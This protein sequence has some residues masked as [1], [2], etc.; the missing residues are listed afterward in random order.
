MPE[1]RVVRSIRE[2][3]P[4][5]W[6][7]CFPGRLET[8]AYLAAVEAA[9]LEGFD[10]RYLVIEADGQVLA[11][12]PG[13]LVDYGLETTLD[14]AA[15]SFISAVRRLYPGAFSL[16]L[17]ALGSPCTEDISV[18]FH[19]AVVRAERG[20]LLARLV[21]AFE[22]EAERC[23]GWLLALKDTPDAEGLWTY[24]AADLGYTRTPGMPGAVL[25]IDFPD[26]EGYLAR[27]SAGTRKDMRRKLKARA[28]LRIETRRDIAGLEGRVMELYRQTRARSDLQFEE[29]T[30][31]YFTG[32]L[33]DMGDRA[34]CVLYWAGGDLLG[35]NL[36]LRDGEALLDKF[37]CMET[38]RGQAHNLYFVSWFTNVQLCLDAGLRRY[39][40]G[41]AGYVT[42]L[43][44]GARLVPHGM[45]F[46]H[47]RALIDRAL[48]W[49]APRLSQ[50]LAPEGAAA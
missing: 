20:P 2:I 21:R 41:Q 30:E 46:R 13:F 27:L 18:G 45:Y 6:D 10:W 4:V 16:R 35:A 12:A 44:L 26:L 28:D 8:H 22:I 19:P 14:G 37:F 36:L 33:R 47:R 3:D 31:R 15:R 32:V 48:R 42:K 9:G 40:A 34:C 49:A 17:A 29:L 50:D 38:A 39:E 25:D 1:A 7:A 5:L 23:G 43:R 11:A 24:T